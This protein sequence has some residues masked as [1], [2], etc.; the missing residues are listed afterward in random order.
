[1]TQIGWFAVDSGQAMIG[2]PCY[3]DNWEPWNDKAEEFSNYPSHKGKYS[4]LGA[5]EATLT[6]GYGELGTGQAVVFTTGYGDGY[7]PV[8]AEM[9]ED[10]RI[11]KVLVMFEPDN[12]LIDNEEE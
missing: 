3:L 7:Y 6:K 2:D 9:N 1:M 11:A 4:Y 5:S 10:G 12:D 8:Y